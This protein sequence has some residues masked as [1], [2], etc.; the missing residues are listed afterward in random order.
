VPR[1]SLVRF[2]RTLAKAAASTVTAGS[3]VISSS[4]VTG[5]LC[6]LNIA[7]VKGNEI[8][9]PEALHVYANAG[10]TAARAGATVRTVDPE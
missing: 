3:D 8:V 5:A 2:L 7:L 1:G 6:K 4:F 9:Y 10:G